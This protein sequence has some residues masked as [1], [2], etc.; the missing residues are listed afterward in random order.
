MESALP[1]VV[2][3]RAWVCSG[4][5]HK[6]YLEEIR[7]K[8]YEIEG[9]DGRVFLR[10]Q[11]MAVSRCLDES[12]RTVTAMTRNKAFTYRMIRS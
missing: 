5:G 11:N 1:E 6:E 7:E 8:D 10:D 12:S 3:R 2:G 9:S 4:E